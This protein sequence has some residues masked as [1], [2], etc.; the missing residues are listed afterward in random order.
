MS[1]FGSSPIR[2]TEPHLPPAE[3][4]G[5]DG[6]RRK[7]QQGEKEPEHDPDHSEVVDLSADAIKAGKGAGQKPGNKPAPTA[8]KPPPPRLD[9][10]A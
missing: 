10:N 1:L 8:K 4:A 7:R 2:P 6:K 9:L 3:R 5:Q